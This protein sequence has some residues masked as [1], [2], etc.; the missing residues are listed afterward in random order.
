[1]SL[2]FTI[3]PAAKLFLTTDI[4]KGISITAAQAKKEANTNRVN[5]IKERIRE[6]KT[7]DFYAKKIT[8]ATSA[9]EKT[10]PAVFN[11][12][13]D[14]FK[15]VE[16]IAMLNAESA[17]LGIGIKMYKQTQEAITKYSDKDLSELFNIEEVEYPLLEQAIINAA[18]IDRMERLED[19]L[20]HLST[21]VYNTIIDNNI[22]I[23]NALEAE[24]KAA[25]IARLVKEKES[26]L[27][28]LPLLPPVINNVADADVRNFIIEES[29]LGVNPKD[30]DAIDEELT[31][32]HL[33]YQ[34]TRNQ[35]LQAIRNAVQSLQTTYQKDF[36]NKVRAYNEWQNLI[37]E[38][39]NELLK[40]AIDL[41]VI[42]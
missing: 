42:F 17:R 13:P 30:Y 1:M 15:A 39:R 32:A 41:K 7:E 6:Y 22:N 8:V 28:R 33:K 18:N 20:P 3:Y 27:R 2:I 10:I 14:E 11:V 19:I 4:Q 25:A 5:K 24:S 16:E 12:Q 36:N 26:P 34:S 9:F 35:V 29:I 40:E 38:K 23:V 31:Q 21:A 37:A